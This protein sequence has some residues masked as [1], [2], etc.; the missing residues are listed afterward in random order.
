M[1]NTNLPQPTAQRL[2]ELV[3]KHL[4]PAVVKKIKQGVEKSA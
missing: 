3:N 2:A 1:R 4:A